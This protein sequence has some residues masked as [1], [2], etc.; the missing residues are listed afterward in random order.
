MLGG[1]TGF[2]LGPIRPPYS[3]KNVAVNK[4]I[5][6]RFLEL[7]QTRCC[8][9]LL[10]SEVSL[11]R[12]DIIAYSVCLLAVAFLSTWRFQKIHIVKGCLFLQKLP[13][14]FWS[15]SKIYGSVTAYSWTSGFCYPGASQWILFLTCSMGKWLFGEN[16]NYRRTVISPARQIFFGLVEFTLGLVRASYSLP[17]WQAV[18]LTFFATCVMEIIIMRFLWLQIQ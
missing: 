11:Q 15:L 7:H 18:K 5:G 14:C 17:E 16:S 10:T 2:F 13:Q 12:N 9:V 4:D 1:S 8:F 3:I 6:K